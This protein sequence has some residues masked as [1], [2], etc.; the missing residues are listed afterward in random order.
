[1]QKIESTHVAIVLESA[2]DQKRG[3]NAHLVAAV[4]LEK[5]TALF[6]KK[7]SYCIYS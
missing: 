5:H 6:K 4:L 1:M 2:K 7:K 3:P